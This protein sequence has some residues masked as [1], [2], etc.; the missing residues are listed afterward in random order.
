[1]FALQEMKNISLL[2]LQKDLTCC[3]L[4]ELTEA[5]LAKAAALPSLLAGSQ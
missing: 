5:H 3:Q 2:E 1:M 4:Y